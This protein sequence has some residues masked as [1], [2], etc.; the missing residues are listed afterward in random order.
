[1]FEV[2][3]HLKHTFRSCCFPHCHRQCV[4]AG[5]ISHTI[6]LDGIECGSQQSH[7][8]RGGRWEI[9][10]DYA[11]GSFGNKAMLAK[12]PLSGLKAN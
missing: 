11:G 3:S 10:P 6:T 12:G 9:E 4:D 8:G 5:K 1:M 2:A 7:I